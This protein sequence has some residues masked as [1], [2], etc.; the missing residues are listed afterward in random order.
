MRFW[1]L[2]STTHTRVARADEKPAKSHDGN[3]D[4]RLRKIFARSPMCVRRKVRQ[5]RRCS[6]RRRRCALADCDTLAIKR[7]ARAERSAKPLDEPRTNGS[8]VLPSGAE[9][10]SEH[11]SKVIPGP[12]CAT[13]GLSACL[14]ACL[15]PK[16]STSPVPTSVLAAIPYAVTWNVYLANVG[17]ARTCT[18]L[19]DE[20]RSNFTAP[21]NNKQSLT[22]CWVSSFHRARINYLKKKRVSATVTSCA[23]EYDKCKSIERMFDATPKKF[24]FAH[25]AYSMMMRMNWS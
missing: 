10:D 4:P 18:E 9:R 2:D 23:R 12:P 11:H 24:E 17:F 1:R 22:D 5:A 25:V 21:L 16:S 6:P 3:G 13:A 7:R 14:P 15:S 8:S 19:T 20:R